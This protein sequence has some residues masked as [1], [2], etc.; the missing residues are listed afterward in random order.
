MRILVI[1]LALFLSSCGGGGG[2]EA[3][4]LSAPPLAPQGL[5]DLALAASVFEVSDSGVGGDSAGD[6][7]VGGAAGDGSALASAVVFLTD[8]QGKT[9]TGRTDPKGGYLLRFKT[10]DYKPPFVVKVVDAGGGILASASE[11]VIPPG[12]A[13]R[14]NVSPLTDKV[15]SDVLPAA[16]SGT[17]K[18]FDGATL[19]TAG[20]VQAKTNLLT[21]IQAALVV[22]GVPDSTQ[23][24]PVRSG[25]K[26]DGTGVDAIIESISHVRDP[27]TGATQLQSKLASLVTNADGTV[28]PVLI[29]A[30]TPLA[31]AQ[32]A[33][34]TNPALT[35]SKMTAW[36]GRWNTCLAGGPAP[37]GT[38]GCSVSFFDSLLGAGS[39]F[40]QN[41]RDFLE[42]FRTLC[43]ETGN[44]CVGGSEFRNPNIL[45]IGRYAGSTTDDL[46]VVEVT[47]RQPRTGPLAG[48]NP[49]PIE[50]TKTLVFKRDDVTAGL[51]AGNWYLHGNQRAFDWSIEPQYFSSIQT[52]AAKL[53]NVS[54]SDPSFMVSGLRLGFSTTVFDPASR[55]FTGS[56]V[57][58]VRLSGPGLPA[59]GLVYVPSSNSGQTGTMRP[60]NK[61]G[62]IPSPG[63]TTTVVGGDFRMAGVV[64]GT[65][66]PLSSAVFGA[67]INQATS[68]ASINFSA[69][70]AFNQYTA[71]IFV[72]TSTTPIVETSRILAPIQSPDTVSRV[73][74]TDLSANTALV[75]PPQPASSSITVQWTRTPGAARIESIFANIRGGGA[76]VIPNTSVTDAFSLAP[77]STSA[78]VSGGTTGFPA[79]AITDYREVGVFGRAG[80]AAYQHSIRRSP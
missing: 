7:G 66:T 3:V 31:A 8:S 57:Y 23:F 43:S 77:T 74:L 72:G 78:V 49:N 29:T 76:S 26:Q 65:S 28:V 20:L 22:A 1:V 45:F 42:D 70:T 13:A 47:I 25:Y 41:S 73:A 56:G 48:N 5:V 63:T 10:T 17:D 79:S 24:D 35:F 61:T 12:K 64:L 9:I 27:A 62:V 19:N 37:N 67:G 52:N 6:G 75:T 18:V 4:P 54:G 16:N 2:G 21:S 34:S 32:V 60:L 44:L 59:A 30:S 15:V 53:G 11:I 14:V 68:P 51:A 71:E 58:A 69:L 40:K 46:A 38:S 33:L 55:S 36:I 80:R 39:T 50:Y